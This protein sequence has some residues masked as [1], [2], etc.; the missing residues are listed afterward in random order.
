MKKIITLFLFALTAGPL[1]S[2]N[3]YF[4]FSNL[5]TDIWGNAND[6]MVG[7]AYIRN[8]TNDTLHVKVKRTPI[9]V[10][11]GSSNSFCWDVCYTSI[12]SESRHSVTMV[13]DSVYTNFYADFLPNGNIG[14]SSIKY[15]FFD[16]DVTADSICVIA[17][18]NASATGIESAIL[19]AG[20]YITDVFP[21]PSN[22]TSQLIY[23]VKKDAANSKIEIHN[24][25]GSLVKVIDLKEKNGSVKLPMEDV[26]SGIYFCSLVVDNK[27]ISTKKL[28]VSK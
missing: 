9:S 13:P 14:L 26:G 11:S 21:N 5:Q 15:C 6:Q 25:L 16:E 4:E 18:F 22:G 10:V 27:T 2:Q 17:Y 20:N 24:I 23:S 8:I 28:V 7:R 1:F 19:P 12:T 3:S